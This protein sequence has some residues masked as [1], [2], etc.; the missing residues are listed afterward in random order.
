MAFVV[1]GRA[2]QNGSQAVSDLTQPQ[3]PQTYPV[4]YVI[5]LTCSITLGCTRKCETIER[6]SAGTLGWHPS[7]HN[8]PNAMK[9]QSSRCQRCYLKKVF[10][11]YNS[12]D[13]KAWLWALVVSCSILHICR[14]L[15]HARKEG[16]VM[17]PCQGMECG[18]SFCLGGRHRTVDVM[19]WNVPQFV[20]DFKWNPQFVS[21]NIIK[22]NSQQLA[23]LNC[24][25]ILVHIG[26][27]SQKWSGETVLPPLVY[28]IIM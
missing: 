13:D 15:S 26:H 6:I 23:V 14:L 18:K 12:S 10:Q 5:L 16:C 27:F 22:V 3:R 21:A 20:S 19:D 1:R 2:V 25:I 24:A 9:R 11:F 4:W 7:E 8:T 17:W 28:Q